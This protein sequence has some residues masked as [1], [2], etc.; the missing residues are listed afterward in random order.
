MV[1]VLDSPIGKLSLAVTPDAVVALS[2]GVVD[3]AQFGD[4]VHTNGG[5]L[6]KEVGRQLDDYFAGS[7]RTF[8]IPLAPVGTPFQKAVWQ[9]LAEI[10]YGATTTYGSVAGLLGDAAKTRAVGAA[11][12]RN[13]IGIIIPCHRVIGADGSLTGFAGGLPTKVRLLDIE[14]RFTGKP[15]RGQPG[16]FDAP[17]PATPLANSNR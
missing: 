12:G 15:R 3:A 9:L 6:V 11:T 1:S 4:C 13:P 7:L 10:P 16:L 8:D 14:A 2:F 17:M 5:S